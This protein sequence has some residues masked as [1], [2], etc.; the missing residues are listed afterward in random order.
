[1]STHDMTYDEDQGGPRHPNNYLSFPKDGAVYQATA[2]ALPW[3]PGASTGAPRMKV[4]SVFIEGLFRF[5]PTDE[6]SRMEDPKAGPEPWTLLTHC[7]GV[8]EY[9]DDALELL[10]T[11]R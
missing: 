8:D 11:E 1:M 5:A 2:V 9:M 7:L 4:P 3:S 10:I 6:P